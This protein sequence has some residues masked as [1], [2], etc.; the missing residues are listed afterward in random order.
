M[1][2]T[3]DNDKRVLLQEFVLNYVGQKVYC[4]I[5]SPD[6]LDE[7]I[8]HLSRIKKAVDRIVVI[9]NNLGDVKKW[10]PKGL[11]I[12]HELGA[13]TYEREWNGSFPDARNEYIQKTQHG[14]WLIV[15]D[16]DEH[17]S[18]SFIDEID[19][20]LDQMNKRKK[21]YA[22]INAHDL[23]YPFNYDR[24][25]DPLPKELISEHM[26]L[27]IFKHL[28]HMHY[29]G[30]G[31][32]KA[33]HEML[34]PPP[35]Q[36]Y[37]MDLPKH[38][39]YVHIK[40]EQEIWER[41]LRNVYIG[42]GGNNAGEHNKSWMPLL[43][44]CH[45]LKINSY[46]ELDEYMKKGETDFLLRKWIIDNR[47]KGMNFEDEMVD[48][49]KYYFYYLHPE[50]KP[51]GIDVI[52]ELAVGSLAELM[53][54]VGEMYLEVLGRHASDDERFHYADLIQKDKIKRVDIEEILKDSS[55]YK[56][57]HR[58]HYASNSDPKQNEITEE[59]PLAYLPLK[60]DIQLTE[61]LIDQIL[62]HS[63]FY[64]EHFKY[65][66]E[67]GKRWMIHAAINYK[68]ETQ[69]KGDDKQELAS[70]KHYIDDIQIYMPLNQ[71]NKI[72][73]IGAG[74]GD[75]TMALLDAGYDVIGLTLGEDNVKSAKERYNITLH[76]EDMHC[77]RF[78]K[79][80]FDGIVLIH[81]YEH[82]YSSVI[83][84]GE[85]YHVLRDYGRIYVAV[86]DPEAEESKTIWHVNL[87]LDWQ[88][89]EE[90]SYWGFRLVNISNGKQKRDKYTFVF[91]K[92]PIGDP[93]FAN[94]GYLR[95]IINLR[96]LLI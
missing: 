51:N 13:E 39:W 34:M 48:I 59:L 80:F 95:H 28:P 52:E 35:P 88:I 96:E 16:S 27:L 23:T 92:L 40:Q 90:F 15:S 87:R 33:V 53:K 26:K 17:F 55:E 58:V 41:A 31:E 1:I 20:V 6:R 14:D 67:I 50:E 47:Q 62:R 83:L 86:P 70:F 94:Y 78:P 69:G 54:F 64:N 36:E 12:L 43:K 25:I 42:G 44:I 74:A 91:E 60:V 73:D 21:L 19:T 8:I 11:D 71:Y 46:F 57:R 24:T 79:N 56:N 61:N 84:L 72:L 38:Y 9:C 93:E 30:I 22:R 82:A 10:D 32:T 75:E 2:K 85:L 65:L 5:A 7:L 89:I 76:E 81:T 37:I 68:I 3:K 66:A 63:K 49:F 77:L 45:S 29:T 18:D 4:T